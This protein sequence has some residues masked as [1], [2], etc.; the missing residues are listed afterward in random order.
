MTARKVNTVLIASGSGTDADSIMKAH[1]SGFIP[2]I[3]IKALIS[4]KLGAGCL[5]KAR[6][7]GIPTKLIDRR[8][9]SSIEIFNTAL[10]SFLLEVEA[11]L[12]FLV[13]CIVNIFPRNGISMYNIHPADP[14][15]FGGSGMYGLE[16]HRRVILD[17]F[18][19]IE[20]G[21]AKVGDRFFT[22]PTIHEVVTDYDSGEPFLQARIEVPTDIIIGLLNDAVSKESIDIAASKLQQVVLPNEWLMLPTAVQMAAKKIIES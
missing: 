15:K 5:D 8:E 16:V 2:N 18:D 22:L 17:I 7:L 19:R 1:A 9:F 4:T 13:G 14:D 21:K 3:N 6:I 10:Y 20:R 11:E 12:V